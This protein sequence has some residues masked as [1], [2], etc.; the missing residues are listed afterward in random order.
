[1]YVSGFSLGFSGILPYYIELPSSATLVAS[2]DATSL[3]F[4]ATTMLL[5]D[6]PKYL[7]M[8][9]VKY[10]SAVGSLRR[11]LVFPETADPSAVLESMLLLDQYEKM[12]TQ[13]PRGS[14]AWTAHARGGI[15]LI[16]HLGGNFAQTTVG[17]GLATRVMGALTVSCGATATM[18]PEALSCLRDLLDSAMSSDI[19]WA[20]NKIL[21]NLIDLQAE[22]HSRGS[23]C[24]PRHLEQAEEL[25]KSFLALFDK[26][27]PSW[28][29]QR[30]YPPNSLSSLAFGEYFEVF[31]N[32]RIRQ[33]TTGVRCMRL[34]LRRIISSSG[35]LDDPASSAATTS[36]L[37]RDICATVA[38]LVLPDASHGGGTVLS[39][40]RQLQYCTLLAP[41]HLVHQVCGGVEMKCWIRRV[42]E[43]M[44]SSG[45]IKAAQ[46]TLNLIHR[47]PNAEYWRVVA[48]VG[49]YAFAT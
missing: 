25:D 6:R 38:A 9:R 16:Q 18:V 49:S 4:L 24:L 43:H 12:M 27:P 5:D 3:A 7:T 20:S 11:D 32:H 23:H 47:E 1:V 33:F 17:R 28:R 35:R 10:G 31:P 26:F 22:L 8:A 29:P 2:I 46:D 48:M 40:L 39:L 14:H 15:S 42:L 44:A 21:A 37:A 36:D 41:L 19:K 13:A 34:I 30:T 45:G